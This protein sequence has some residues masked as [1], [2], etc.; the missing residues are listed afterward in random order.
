ME[1]HEG[2]RAGGRRARAFAPALAAVLALLIAGDAAP[3]A[4]AA[5]ASL[6]QS[7]LIVPKGN[8]ASPFGSPRKIALPSGWHGEVW[9]RVSGA[10][11]AAWTPQGQLLVS[12]S[13]SGQ[14]LALSP[15]TGGGAASQKTLISGLTAPQGLAFDAI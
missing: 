15:G 10:R 6:A 9:A 4:H 2:G 1:A 3:G 13:A 11:F 7:A 14:V 8:E 12:A 5:R